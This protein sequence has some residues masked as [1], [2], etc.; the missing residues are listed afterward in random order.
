M[1]PA[2]SCNRGEEGEDMQ[3]AV[4][5]RTP[6]HL[7]IVGI[8][9]FVWSCFGAY[10]YTMTRMRNTD[11]IA[12]AMPGTDPNTVLAWV[13]AFPLY[14]QIGWA[15]GVWMGLLGS[16]LL[17]LRSRWAVW[18]Y[19]LSLVGAVLGLGYQI[20]LAPPLEGAH[21]TALTRMIPYIII[22]IAAALVWYANTMHKKGVLR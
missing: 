6:A 19:A 15:L 9:S 2:A 14:A 10:D 17:L 1:P 16:L 8:L 11:Y 21:E 7:W 18:S 13:D 5:A 20:A 12:A 3:Q 22:L 4:S